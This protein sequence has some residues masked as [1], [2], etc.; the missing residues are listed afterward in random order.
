M[1]LAV[2][3]ATCARSQD[4][5]FS[6]PLEYFRRLTSYNQGYLWVGHSWNDSKTDWVGRVYFQKFVLAVAAIPHS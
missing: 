5:I 3:L 4:Q 1:K 2:L 6:T